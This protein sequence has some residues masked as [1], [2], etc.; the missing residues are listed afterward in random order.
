MAISG[1]RWAGSPPPRPS[2]PATIS[3][4]ILNCVVLVWF[5]GALGLYSRNRMAR[6][7]Q[8]AWLGSIIGVS[9]SLSFFAAGL[10]GLIVVHVYPDAEMTQAREFSE[11]G[12]FF[13]LVSGMTFFSIALG[14]YMRLLLGLFQVRR[15]IYAA[16]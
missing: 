3:E 14:I 13:A 12:Y 9:V 6:I 16:S 4:L 7:D 2:H 5:A 11:S 10:L 15:E 1:C 8:L